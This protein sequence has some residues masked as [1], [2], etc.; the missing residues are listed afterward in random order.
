[1]GMKDIRYGGFML[2]RLYRL[3]MVLALTACVAVTAS[4]QT[5]DPA[6]STPAPKKKARLKLWS[7]PPKDARGAK[8]RAD[9]LI[10]EKF[11]RDNPDIDVKTASG[12]KLEGQLAFDAVTMSIAGGTAPDVMYVNFRKST[13]FI[14]EGFFLPLESYID[15]ATKDAI[16]PKTR[17]A[18]FQKGPP[19]R[20]E[21]IYAVP[22]GTPLIM[23]LWYNKVAFKRAGLDPN[24]PPKN[25]EEFIEY[26]KKMSDPDEGT[27]GWGT[28][29]SDEAAWKYFNFIYQAGGEVVK[30][31]ANGNWIACY[32]DE[33]GVEALKFYGRL[34]HE[35]YTTPSGKKAKGVVCVDDY[36]KWTQNKVGMIFDYLDSLQAMPATTNPDINGIAPLPVGP[37][38]VGGGEFNQT[39]MGVNAQIRQT[40]PPDEAEATIKAA[41]KYIKYMASDEPYRIYTQIYVEEG[42]GK[43]VHPTW[44]K[45]F[46]YTAILDEINPEWV[47]ANNK[48]FEYAHPEPFGK[49]CDRI[50]FELAPLMDKIMLPAN[51]HLDFKGEL[52]KAV[53]STNEKLLGIISDKEMQ[54]RKTIILIALCL[55]GA[56]LIFIAIKVISTLSG[57]VGQ[58]KTEAKVGKVPL[59]IHVYAWLF[60]GVAVITVTLW[61][62]L[63]VFRGLLM[64]FQDYK[65]MDS[66]P[67]F[68]SF[69]GSFVGLENFAKVL[70]DGLFWKAMGNTL[71]YVVL[72]MSLGFL[73]PIFLALLLNEIPK[74]SLFFRIIFYLPTITS[75]IVVLLLWKLFYDP[76]QAGLLNT[77]IHFVGIKRQMWLRDPNLAMLC[78][79]IPGIWAG[80]GSGSIF[81]LA[82]LKNVPD[83]LYESA[84]IDGAGIWKKLWNV[85]F[86]TLKVIITMNFVGAFIG[87]FYATERILLMTGG[88]PA[89]ATHVVGLEVFY[90]AFV[91][92]KF[93]YATAIAWILGSILVGFT[94]FQLNMLK[95]VR[96]QTSANKE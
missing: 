83:E 78:V 87:S 59:R 8:M 12:I 92:L 55:V 65:V 22:Y 4:A 73:A 64:A 28:G 60:M 89:Y 67:F 17:K 15:Q 95:D 21:H 1:M 72:S 5:A 61:G 74:G 90:N 32:N 56:F 50:Y 34:F 13:T 45:K 88:G 84:A 38:G 86:P 80:V 6:A 70:W 44:L 77:I 25:W 11:V 66:R 51:D 68:E 54:K 82:A 10:F 3:V 93:G 29:R 42:L 20:G 85:T 31:D 46:G 63:P 96:F 7:I 26:A 39:M 79:I 40:L 81:Y 14:Q 58:K 30:Q 43:F 16:N 91:Y 35:E 48:A 27:Y 47:A 94:I 57:I 52:D 18:V 37:T 41:V 76:S 23:A 24:K 2:N 36:T 49:N 19:D 71:M 9:R 69:A 62:Y 75:G 53:A 33:H